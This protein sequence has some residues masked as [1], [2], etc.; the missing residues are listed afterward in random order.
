M[1]KSIDKVMSVAHAQVKEYLMKEFEHLYFYVSPTG[2]LSYW[3]RNSEGGDGT[4][5]REEQKINVGQILF[6]QWR[7]LQE[8]NKKVALAHT[9]PKEYFYCTHC[10]ETKPRSEYE[11]FVMAA[12]YCKE[13]AKIPEVA[14][15]ITE[16]HK[17]G[18]YD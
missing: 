7:Y 8:L 3:V 9:N 11:D 1:Q 2:K 15:A 5:I 17:R 4:G 18:F 14:K 16:S 10:G 6:H 12:D 13:C